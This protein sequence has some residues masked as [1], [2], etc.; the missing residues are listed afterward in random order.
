MT[1]G[2]LKC[3]LQDYSDDDIVVIYDSLLDEEDQLEGDNA[4]LHFADQ[5]ANAKH[6]ERWLEY[7]GLSPD[8]ATVIRFK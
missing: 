6:F 4:V 7:Q 2:K 1:V 8:E 5:I 3:E